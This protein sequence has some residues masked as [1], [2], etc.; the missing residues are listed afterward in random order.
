LLTA[1]VAL[2]FS[3]PYWWP[4]DGIVGNLLSLSV[5]EDTVYADGYADA[6][7]RAARI[8]MKRDEIYALLGPPLY[9]WGN[10]EW[11]SRSPADTHYRERAFVFEGD[12]T[13]EKISGFWFD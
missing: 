11:W 1:V 8:G 9:A 2:V 4:L 13:V 3:A 6:S 12:T 5:K 10:V 7:F